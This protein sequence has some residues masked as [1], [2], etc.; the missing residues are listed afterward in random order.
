MGWTQITK[1][2]CFSFSLKF[3]AIFD[4]FSNFNMRVA[5]EKSSKTRENEKQITKFAFQPITQWSFQE[6]KLVT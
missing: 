4:D 2:L 5:V 6:P 3:W 1:N